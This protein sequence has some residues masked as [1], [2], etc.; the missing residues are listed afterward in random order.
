MT[1]S[2]PSQQVAREPALNTLLRILRLLAIVVWVGGLIFF[3]FVLAPVAFNVLPSTHDA[4]SIVGATLRVLNQIG[5]ACGVVFALAN[6]ASIRGVGSSKLKLL[7]AQL[8]LVIIMLAATKYVQ[9]RIVP[10]ME[11]DR[12]AAGGDIDAAP[13]DNAARLDFERLHP[14]S[15]KV[16]GAALLLGIGVVVLMGLEGRNLRGAD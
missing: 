6:F 13:A 5:Y 12:I 10:A 14:L 1:S 15:E 3:A 9:A 2:I 8:L 16:E 4:G 7:R 11:R